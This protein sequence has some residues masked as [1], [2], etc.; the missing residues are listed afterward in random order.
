ML[1]AMTKSTLARRRKQSWY[2]AK[3]LIKRALARPV[4]HAVMRRVATLLGDRIRRERLPAPASLREVTAQMAG[5]TFV[6]QRPD[7]CIVAK[8]LYWGRGQRPR[9]EDQLALDTFAVLARDAQLVLDVG[10]YT[11]IFSLLAA[12]VSPA[13]QVHAF[14]VVP[15]VAQAALHNMAA[16]DLSERVA[17][18]A[19]G[20]G[21]DGDTVQ[22]AT[23]SGGSA[24]PD[25]YSTKEHF[26]DGVTVDVSSL[27][28]VANG[29]TTPPPAAVKIDV[30]GTE[31]TVLLHAQSFLGSHR[32]DILCEILAGVADTEAVQAALA[33]HGY[34]YFR[35]EE[36]AL[37]PHSELVASERYRDWLFT[38]R[39]DADLASVGIPLAAGRGRR[40]MSGPEY[41]DAQD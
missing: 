31:D 4:P 16:N 15:D 19:R 18:H 8:E 10:A 40:E 3:P 26:A 5:V 22:I 17:V 12:R 28:A 38:T 14:E 20:I 9:P 2:G 34:R 27:D 33:P 24:L 11:G 36:H 7:R 30:E 6:M 39:S 23:G 25:F 35:V 29:L 1:A 41:S 37:A 13:A 32:P 21:K